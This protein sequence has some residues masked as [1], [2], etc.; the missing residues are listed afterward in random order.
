MKRQNLVLI[1]CVCAIVFG[2]VAYAQ[3]P[4]QEPVATSP[5][6]FAVYELIQNSRARKETYLLNR[7]T[8]DSWQ[9][10]ETTRRYAWQKISK[11]VH[12]EDA[13]PKDWAEPVYQVSTSGLTVKGTYMVNV[14]TGATWLL[15][16]DPSKGLFWGVIQAPNAGVRRPRGR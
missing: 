5:P 14:I 7:Y 10:V 4:K 16:E 11:E 2:A 13:V 3:L 8:G 9:L 15:F 6:A 1:G 12:N